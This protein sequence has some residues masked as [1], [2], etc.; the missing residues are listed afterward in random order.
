MLWR[1]GLAKYVVP[2]VMKLLVL[3]EFPICVVEELI[4]RVLHRLR[5]Q[6]HHREERLVVLLAMLSF[7]FFL[8][9]SAGAVANVLSCVLLLLG[10]YWEG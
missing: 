6:V 3:E 8:A 9:G 10:H 7:S 1:L 2:C 4:R 5:P